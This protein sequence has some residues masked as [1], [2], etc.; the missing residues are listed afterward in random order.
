MRGEKQPG[1]RVGEEGRR[2][3]HRCIDGAEAERL[4]QR[5]GHRHLVAQRLDGEA[6]QRRRRD[7]GDEVE[8]VTLMWF[9]DIKSVRA[10]VGK[11]YEVSHV[12]PAA[13]AVLARHDDR[14][15]HFQGIDRRPQS[16]FAS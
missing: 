2:E 15:A 4:Q 6:E 8:F 5:A 9:D 16:D 13:K 11:D 10:F 14:S 3:P 7:L 12:P 1:H